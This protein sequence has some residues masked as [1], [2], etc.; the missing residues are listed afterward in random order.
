MIRSNKNFKVELGR[1]QAAMKQELD[2]NEENAL[3]LETVKR[4]L[5]KTADERVW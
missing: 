2:M 3:M 1:V 4:N 5:A